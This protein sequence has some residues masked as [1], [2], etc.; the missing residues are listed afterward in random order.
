MNVGVASVA[1]VVD[2][3]LLLLMRLFCWMDGVGCRESFRG[4]PGTV[5]SVRPLDGRRSGAGI[6]LVETEPESRKAAT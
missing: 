5:M 1:D 4:I 2:V 3:A 6:G